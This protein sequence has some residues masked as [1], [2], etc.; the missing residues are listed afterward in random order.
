MKGKRDLMMI[1]KILNGLTDPDNDRFSSA[2]EER[3]K[4]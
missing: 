4:I 2:W 3:T 1:N